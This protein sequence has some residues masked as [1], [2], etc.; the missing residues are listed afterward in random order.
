MAIYKIFPVNDA[1]IYS[2][3][4][5][6]GLNAGLDEILELTE[7]QSNTGTDYYPSRILIKFKDSEIQDVF[8][9]KIGTNPYSASLQLYT[10]ENRELAAT[11]IIEAYPISGAWDN[12]TGKYL[13][14]PTSSNG[15]SWTYRDNNITATAWLTSSFSTGVT[16][17]F[18]GSVYGGGN[19]YTGSGFVNTASF[20]LVDNL[21][22]DINVTNVIQKYSASL[23]ASQTYPTGITNNG[24]ILKRPD[25]E[26][27]G[28]VNQGLLQ[29]FSLET[30]TIFPPCL[31]FKWDDS[32][33]I[34][35]SGTVLTSGQLYCTLA[36][37]KEL[38]KQEEE[39]TF[40]LNVRK[41][42]P[43]RTFTTSSN[44]LS[45]NYF[46]SESYYSI[47]DAAT[48]LEVIPFD[49]DFTKISADSSGMYFKIWMNGLEPERYYKLIFKH[50]NNDGVTIFDN[51]DTFK[52]VR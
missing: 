22:L 14:T 27:F 1:T 5:R 6:Q 47:R 16:A 34:I 49:S 39:Y 20:T 7:Q 44:Y 15:V 8:Q 37:N 46:T 40:R 43:T 18:S 32:S 36:N 9:N 51:N 17:S 45:V 41:R 13:N 23:F 28:E 35:G 38:F 3:P 24:F 12:G 19:W 48:E 42:Y 10:T 50:V 11:Q 26:E 33:Y 25:N 31:T 29:Y 52:I 30:H 4:L 21:D 2:H